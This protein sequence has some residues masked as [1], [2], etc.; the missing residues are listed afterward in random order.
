M[1]GIAKRC[2]LAF[3]FFFAARALAGSGVRPSRK[4]LRDWEKPKLDAPDRW[5]AKHRCVEA[6]GE[7]RRF[8]FQ[9]SGRRLDYTCAIPNGYKDFILTEMS[10]RGA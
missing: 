7:M 2:A 5:L 8:F 4:R 6:R 9:G 1:A 3:D 10:C